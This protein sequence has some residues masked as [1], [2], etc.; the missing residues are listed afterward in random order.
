MRSDITRAAAYAATPDL[1]MYGMM[2]ALLATAIWLLLATYWELP[3]SSTHAAVSA[4]V[5]MSLVARG[6]GSVL[7]SATSDS[8]PYLRGM[9]AILLGWC[10]APPAAGAAAAALFLIT[11]HAGESTKSGALSAACALRV[12]C[13]CSAC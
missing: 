12:L 11:R 10:L 13:V 4:V 2:C 9:S 6:G 3:V 8:F 7:W 1:L 5:G